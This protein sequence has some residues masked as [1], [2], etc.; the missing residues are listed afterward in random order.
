MPETIVTILASTLLAILP[1][2]MLGIAAHLIGVDPREP[3][4]DSHIR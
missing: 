2:A 4:A 1:F 3:I